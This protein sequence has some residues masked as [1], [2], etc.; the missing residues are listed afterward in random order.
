MTKDP[1][2]SSPDTSLE[3]VARLMC[4]YDC[5]EIPIVDEDKKPVGVITDRDITCRTVA[6]GKNPLELTAGDCMT[7]SCV[8]ISRDA[9]LEECCAVMEEHQI[10]RVPVVDEEGCC[11]GIVAQ[12]D[13]ALKAPKEK[14]VE[15][16][17]E[18]SKPE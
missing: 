5:G 15:V 10:R 1:Q 11:C 12:A 18:V 7:K 2:C 17:E 6:G 3:E 4:E 13:L 14:V 9:S 8:T 16:L